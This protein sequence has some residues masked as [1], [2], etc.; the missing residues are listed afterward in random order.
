MTFVHSWFVLWLLWT[1]FD[2]FLSTKFLNEFLNTSF[3]QKWKKTKIYKSEYRAGNIANGFAELKSCVLFQLRYMLQLWWRQPLK[4]KVI[5]SLNKLK[6]KFYQQVIGNKQFLK[7]GLGHPPTK[8]IA[9]N[10]TF[11]T[12]FTPNPHKWSPL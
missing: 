1:S 10:C 9:V 3:V 4:W 8:G 6:I 7:V 2:R 12:I 11:L 5:F